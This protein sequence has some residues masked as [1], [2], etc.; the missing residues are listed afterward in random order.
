ML[1][2]KLTCCCSSFNNNNKKISP[3]QLHYFLMMIIRNFISQLPSLSS[4]LVSFLKLCGTLQKVH[5]LWYQY[6]KPKKNFSKNALAMQLSVLLISEDG[7]RSDLFEERKLPRSTMWNLSS[8][9]LSQ[10]HVWKRGSA[11]QEQLPTPII[12]AKL[13][14]THYFW[15]P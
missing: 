14:D 4:P 13:S 2:S 9:I 5:F 12:G 8:C 15:L 11:G 3:R 10:S 6:R 7:P 1:K